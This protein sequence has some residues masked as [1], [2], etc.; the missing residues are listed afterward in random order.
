MKIQATYERIFALYE[1]LL[2][3]LLRIDLLQVRRDRFTHKVISYIRAEDKGL[4]EEA[5]QTSIFDVLTP[6]ECH[7]YY[8]H[9]MKKYALAVFVVSFVTTFPESLSGMVIACVI[10]FV[11]FQAVLYRAMQ[12]MLLLYGKDCDLN[13][14][15]NKGVQTIISIES[16]GLM[17]GKYPILQKMK[18]VVGWMGRQI[19]K[20]FGPRV[21][22]RMSNT[23]F[24]I[25]RRQAVKWVSVDTVKQNVS[26]M[27]DALVPI[28]CAVISGLVSVVILVPMCNKLRKHLMSK[29]ETNL[30]CK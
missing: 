9:M 26:L 13:A 17:I 10:D 16:S 12:S 6:K 27:F 24:M 23:V 1:H 8:V 14:D 15:E 22:A 30:E 7:R 4:F 18:S 25:A 21:T 29:K 2:S 19:V 3:Y 28:T 20:R 5:M 11:L